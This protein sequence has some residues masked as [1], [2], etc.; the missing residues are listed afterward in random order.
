MF[1]SI[2]LLLTSLLLHPAQESLAE[3]QYNPETQRLEIALRLSLSDEQQLLR[4]ESQSNVESVIEDPV[5]LEKHAS[6]VL[7]KRIRFSRDPEIKTGTLPAEIAKR[8][9]WIGRQ[10][11]GGHVWWFFEYAAPR[12]ELG[13][14]R[15]TLFVHPAHR[16]GVTKNPSTHDHVHADPVNTFLILPASQA[17]RKRPVKSF[18]TTPDRPVARIPW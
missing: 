15:C 16:T 8:Y 14:V 3:L 17:G 12:E 1:V 7:R 10:S 18:S 2:S 9:R 6:S 5:A 13:H 4:S 11:E